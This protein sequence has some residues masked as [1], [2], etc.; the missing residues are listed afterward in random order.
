MKKERKFFKSGI[1]FS[2][3]LLVLLL[4][5]CSAPVDSIKNKFGKT[6]QTEEDNKQPVESPET[7]GG[8][9]V[10]GESE[11][12]EK[13]DEA[14]ETS[15]GNREIKEL[16]QK[17]SESE[18]ELKYYKD[19]VKKVV[20]KLSEKEIQGLIENEWNY[21]LTVNNV[22]FPSNGVLEINSPTIEF[23]IEE[24]RVP[25]SV[26]TEEQSLKGK[27]NTS[28][29]KAF[30][31]SNSSKLDRIVDK[32]DEETF[33]KISYNIFDTDEGDVFELEITDELRT[34][35]SLGVNKLKVVRK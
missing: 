25:Y 11:G 6:E 26:L 4:S 21:K 15:E 1:L 23:N 7:E 2:S 16:S 19:Y 17:L 29:E 30:S 18:D 34:K 20:N 9:D 32:N 31:F 13:T 10:E 14:E 33:T 22:S 5:A 28:L 3:L 24:K 27:I 12:E 35:L 8:N